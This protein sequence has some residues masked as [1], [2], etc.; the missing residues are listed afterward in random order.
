[1]TAD[2]HKGLKKSWKIKQRKNLPGSRTILKE[3]E[4][5]EER[6]RKLE[7]KARRSNI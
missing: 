5:K 4:Y 1:M 3:M 2:I 6:I 7:D